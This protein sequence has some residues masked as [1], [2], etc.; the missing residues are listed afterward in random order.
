[1]RRAQ[2]R[3]PAGS[4]TPG[5]ASPTLGDTSP[6]EDIQGAAPRHTN[7]P[8]PAS[9]T[10]PQKNQ[11]PHVQPRR[12]TP[13][14]TIYHP[15]ISHQEKKCMRPRFVRE[16]R[17]PQLLDGARLESALVLPSTHASRFPRNTSALPCTNCLESAADNVLA[18]TTDCT[19]RQHE[20]RT[21]PRQQPASL[22][23]HPSS[24]AS[25]ALL[26]GR[27]HRHDSRTPAAGF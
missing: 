26:F 19:P 1:M 9:R 23:R 17:D 6:Q 3:R 10:E 12:K 2:R 22:P 8:L 7:P 14:L 18:H 21:R 27:V 16:A 24:S 4:A 15:L 5:R 20:P 13:G 25:S 11:H